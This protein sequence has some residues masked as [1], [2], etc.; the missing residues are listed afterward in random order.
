MFIR[1]RLAVLLALLLSAGMTYYHVG[2]FLPRAMERGAARGLGGGYSFG[3]DFYP[4][5]LTSREALLRHRNPYSPE[6]TRAIQTG[7]FGRPLDGR[8]AAD[9]PRDYRAFAYPV[10]VDLL[11]WPLALLPFP[12]V[13]I[14]LAA[15]LAALTTLSIPLWLRALRRRASTSLLAI[16]ILLT[17][18]SYAVLE[19]LFAVQPGLVVGFLLAA[20]FAALAKERLFLAGS[21]FAFTL[22]KPQMS[23]VVAV[24]L[25]LW[26]FA[27][28]RERRGFV[29]GFFA[30]SAA[31]AGLSL[32][33]WPHWI[34]Q[35]LHVLSGYGSYSPPPLITYSLGPRLGPLLGPI[36]IIALLIV[37]AVLMWR[38]RSVETASPLFSLTASLLLALTSITLLPGQAVYDHVILLPGIL[39]ILWTW[40]DIVLTSRPFGVV[41]AAAAL[42]LAWQWIAA[43]PV[44]AARYFLAPEQF[45]ASTLF[46]LPLRAAASVPMAV[47]AVLGFVMWKTMRGKN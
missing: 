19:G 13:R 8:S 46:L 37:A 29:Y 17:L 1:P 28:W 4:I 39:V 16:L 14:G 36:L 45:F 20:S 15:A 35:W 25:L 21:L 27:G 7:I 31:L 33:V 22:I 32:I 43:I 34:P 9:T 42:A 40:R 18:S 6:M 3:N 38:M 11:F 44:L 41:L 10:F 23:A 24:Y 2:L 30:W 5:W 47:A 12:A 26:S